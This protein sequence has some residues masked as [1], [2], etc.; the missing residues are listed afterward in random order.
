MLLPYMQYRI[1]YLIPIVKHFCEGQSIKLFPQTMMSHVDILYA[2]IVRK[3]P[4]Q[5]EWH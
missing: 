2:R 3:I 1:G 4:P 5:P